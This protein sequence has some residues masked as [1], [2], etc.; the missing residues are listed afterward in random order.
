[1]IEGAR[2]HWKELRAHQGF[3]TTP[4]Q[5]ARVTELLARSKAIETFV[6][7]EI[8]K[9]SNRNVTVGELYDAYARYCVSKEWTPT[10]ERKFEEASQ[11]LILRHWGIPKSHS[12]ERNKKSKRGYRGI[13]LVR[14]PETTSESETDEETDDSLL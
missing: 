5:K 12:L 6:Q 1:M 13:A 14:P 9:D 7:T 4:T 8:R 11:H 10:T 2:K 3:S